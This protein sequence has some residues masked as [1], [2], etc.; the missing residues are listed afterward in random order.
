MILWKNG[1]AEVYLEILARCE[2]HQVAAYRNSRI[3]LIIVS[4][5]YLYWWHALQTLILVIL[6]G[7]IS[8]W[9]DIVISK[10]C[11]TIIWC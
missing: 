2:E 3:V 6:I 8:G 7:T 4:F 11:K 9:S 1:L 10:V 5:E